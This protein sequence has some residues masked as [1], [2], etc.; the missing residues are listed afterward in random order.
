MVLEI[1]SQGGPLGPR[2]IELHFN[3]P[4]KC[5]GRAHRCPVSG[6]TT[7]CLCP[8]NFPSLRADGQLARKSDANTLLLKC[9]KKLFLQAGVEQAVQADPHVSPGWAISAEM[10]RGSSPSP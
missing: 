7:S 1:P 3:E 9:A 4:G 2:F 8:T 6:A 5:P 10:L